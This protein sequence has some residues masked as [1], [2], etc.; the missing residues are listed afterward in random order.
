MNDTAQSSGRVE[1]SQ[2]IS[3]NNTTMNL[4]EGKETAQQIRDK[5]RDR[6]EQVKKDIKKEMPLSDQLDTRDPQ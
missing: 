2:T 1:L 4:E 6:M 3:L 5:C